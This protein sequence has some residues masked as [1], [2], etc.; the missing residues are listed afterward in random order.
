MATKNND[1]AKI[2]G[3]NP[4]IAFRFNV[5]LDKHYVA[6]FTECSGLGVERETETYAEGGLN[7]YVH[8]LP[9]RTKYT[10]IVLKRGIVKS[11]ALWDWCQEGISNGNVRRASL[12]IEL[13]NPGGEI[14]KTW[15]VLDAYPVKWTG[16]TLNTGNAEMAVETIEIAHHG[17]KLGQ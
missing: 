17:L 8:I 11:D 2:W 13:Y 10:N 5:I 14:L 12:S 4:A 7:E 1:N 3:E 16:P 15:D 6:A 9:G